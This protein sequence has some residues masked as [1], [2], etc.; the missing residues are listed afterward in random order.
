M[1]FVM[2]CMFLM[3]ENIVKGYHMLSDRVDDKVLSK[4][5]ERRMLVFPW[6]VLLSEQILPF[7]LFRV[8]VFFVFF[9]FFGA[10]AFDFFVCASGQ[11]LEQEKQEK[12]SPTAT[13][14]EF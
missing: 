13:R 10:A 9:F 14:R 11:E 2:D 7:S 8:F 3:L 4:L 1:N 6:G 12:P 5:T